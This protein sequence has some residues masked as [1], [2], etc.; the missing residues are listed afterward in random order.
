M[1]VR[2]SPEVNA[3]LDDA[4]ALS[5]R[6]GQQ[7]VG[8]E[9]LFEALLQNSEQ[10]PGCV[11]PE[12]MKNLQ[13]IARE[14]T[15]ESWRGSLPVASSEVFYTPR[16]AQI[17]S[18][19]TR[20]A[21]RLGNGTAQAGH[22]LLALL[23]DK[24]AA[25]SRVMD[26]LGLQRKQL[27]EMLRDD[28]HRNRRRSRRKERAE[29]KRETKASRA[30]AEEVEEQEEPDEG[31]APPMDQ[32]LES[33]TRDLTALAH[34]GKLE[35]AIGR[36]KE[37]FQILEVLTRKNKNNVILVGEAGTGKTHIVEGLALALVS[38]KTSGILEGF[39]I[40]ELSMAAL[41]AGT[42]YRGAFEERIQ[43]LLEELKQSEDV[44]LFID[45]VHL[46]MGAGATDG[47]S[48]DLANLLKPA[49]A[50]GELRCI[51][52]TTVQEYR[53]F[54]EKDPAIE[55]RFQM[56]RV[57]E[58][59]ANATQEV[60]AK[61]KP[62]L[63]EYHGVKISSKAL[64]AAVRL[65]HRYMPE[66][67][68]PDKAIDVLDQA[69]ARYRLRMVSA[70]AKK[71]AGQDDTRLRE[72]LKRE[73][74]TPHDIRKV[75]AQAT[76]IP[77]EEITSSER[78]Q[79]T[80]LE[81]RLRKR[82]VGQDVAVQK[83]ASVVKKSRAGLADPN[84]PDAVMMFLGPT[85]VG[86]TQLAKAM[87]DMLFGAS[88]HLTTFD[89]SE[90]VEAHSVSR[91]L[92]APPGYV[93]SEEEGRLSAAVRTTPFSILLF[94][95]VEKAHRQVFDIFLPILDEGR[96]KD[97]HGRD[98]SFRNCIIIF[99]SNVGAGLMR[100]QEDPSEGQLLE[101]LRKHFRP[102]FINRIDEIVPFYPLL[103]EDIRAILKLSF[104]D[105]ASRLREKG[106]KLR[107]YQRAYEYLS[108]KGY[109][110][111]FGARELR[112]V[113]ERLVVNPI[114][115]MMLEGKVASGQCVE[116]LMEDGHLAL[117]QGEMERHSSII[118]RGKE[119]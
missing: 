106:I 88:K 44:I 97:A 91:L 41:T 103:F 6:R 56:V 74:V 104:R 82:V 100:A 50:R 75:V 107:V 26:R 25:P 40:L 114:S 27:V 81:R 18:E 49:L 19:T 47:S 101:A 89:M 115:D 70:T 37:T 11:T 30:Y 62:E 59:S 34:R 1:Q 118:K 80:N 58:L 7:Y 90:Y 29:A 76:S 35:P 116:V 14:M 53:R 38:G 84:R 21:E 4:T 85:G 78:Q 17:L 9:G 24:H 20:M 86:K 10:L 71:K 8:V 13:I 105:V 102:E 39:R 94:D 109:S 92:G 83:V 60:L 33:L 65:T 93:G 66:R 46:I 110:E 32:T 2:V 5:A 63:E 73:K 119:S 111:E 99:T 22:L 45:E 51:G 12:Y 57:E 113:V 98:I 16:C 3:L 112:R 23:C 28:L 43:A 36:S 79:L 117:R 77:I 54:I 15:T 69:C 68:F 55:R 31:A 67:R 108:E 72:L 42:Q 96:L 48:T 64:S 52:A 61:M 87:A 95:E